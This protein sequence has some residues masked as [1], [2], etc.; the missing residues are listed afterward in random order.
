[1]RVGL[2]AVAL[3]LG[4]GTL[5]GTPATAPPA[6]AAPQA[7]PR[8]GPVGWE[9]FRNPER[10][11]EIGTDSRTLQFSSFDRSGSNNDGF[12]GNYSCLRTTPDNACVIAEQQ[13]AGEIDSIWFTRDGGDVRNTGWIRIELDGQTVVDTSLQDVVD[14]KLGAPFVYPLVANADQSSGGV[15]LKVPMTY[16]ENMRVTVQS[17]PFFYH[18]TY[19]TFASPDGIPTFDKNDKAEDVLAKLK[20][21]GTQ[22]PKPQEPHAQTSNTDLNVAPG[23]TATIATA[24][25]SG[26]V[27]ALSF[28][29]DQLGAHPQGTDVLRKARLRATF[30]GVRTIDSPLGEFYGSGLGL[31]N[32]KSFMFGMDP[33][34]KK[35]QAWWLMPYAKSAKLELYNGSGEAI[36]GTA[37]T[38]TSADAKWATE[39][40]NGTAGHFRATSQSA[41]ATFGRDVT[42]LETVGRGRVVGVTQTVEGGPKSGWRLA[43]LEGDERVFV[44]G[45]TSPTLHGTGTEDFYEGGWYFNRDAFTTPTTGTPVKD[46]ADCVEGCTGMYRLLLAEGMN[47]DNSMRF[48]IEHGQA[49]D[50]P[51]LEAST[52]YWYGLPTGTQQWSDS[53]DVGSPAS[54]KAHGYSAS[55]LGKVTKLT[56]RFEGLDGPAEPVTLDSRATNAQVSFNVAVPAANRGVTLRRTSDQAKAYQSARVAV[57]GTA[58]GTWYQPLG[59]AD[60]RWLDDSFELPASLTA[61]K[62]SLTITLS[63][64]AGSPPW[65]AA[66]Y[67]AIAKLPIYRDRANPAMISGVQTSTGTFNQIGLSW[68]PARDDVYAP[69][70]QVYASTTPG[71]TPGPGNLVGTTV[72]P[73]FTHHD[74]APRET[75]YYRIRAVDRSGR[76]GPASAQV[77]GVSGD[78]VRIEAE[79]LLPPVS[80]EAPLT[81]QGNCCGVGWSGGA[82]LWFT[83]TEP[84]KKFTVEFEIKTAGKY[85]LTTQQTLA[86][87]Y[88]INT[89][90]IDGTTIGQP[91]DGYNF[92]DVKI[93]PPLS[94][95]AH[96]LTAGKHTLTLTVGSKNPA[97]ISY[98]AGI[99][100]LQFQRVD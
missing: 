64:T 43:Y 92:P 78:I 75:W 6:S 13:G 22:D 80:A 40:A 71:F 70:Y 94:Y 59:N 93:S 20:A 25:G 97:S 53:I 84:G 51:A 74:L 35:L 79:R 48:T 32:V 30:D 29:I 95:G 100:Y 36:T 39:L 46:R 69:R 52:T 91:F 14:G 63:P 55:D 41:H 16:R 3:A 68:Q 86:R 23:A 10:L 47:F 82:Q 99:D 65:N 76:V 34:T 4:I 98:M 28:A 12:G 44:D 87:D 67:Q 50:E 72:T 5:A 24:K 56:S 45:A 49:N 11:A 26:A 57:D 54:E 62:R 19:R 1:M 33:A 96:D 31:Y 85:E 73:G 66:A 38:T 17:N 2:V 61:G 77:V 15:Y 37:T 83:P 27:S 7:A 89:L 8:H 18:V 88:G 9:T 58:V 60:Q 90:A 42:F 21:S 81:A